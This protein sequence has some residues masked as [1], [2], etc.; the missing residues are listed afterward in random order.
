MPNLEILP[1]PWLEI[2]DEPWDSLVWRVGQGET[3]WTKWREWFLNLAA[4]AREAYQVQYPEPM[5]WKEFYSYSLEAQDL[6]WFNE[7]DQDRERELR[8]RR[9][10]ANG[11]GPDE[12]LASLRYDYWQ[13][14][15]LL[16]TH[17]KLGSDLFAFLAFQQ[18]WRFLAFTGKLSQ[19]KPLLNAESDVRYYLLGQ[20]PEHFSDAD[21]ELLQSAFWRAGSQSQAAK[22]PWSLARKI[23]RRCAREFTASLNQGRSGSGL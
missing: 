23:I 1:P 3:Y 9:D 13:Y 11:V 8:A 21:V 18:G 17:G 22:M 5:G 15:P 12:E 19:L 14:V 20:R 2:P 7:K 6:S 4:E 16:Y 10:T